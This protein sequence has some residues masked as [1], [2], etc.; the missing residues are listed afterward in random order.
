MDKLEELAQQ[1][2][3]LY[4]Q[5]IDEAIDVL[6]CM[7]GVTERKDLKKLQIDLANNGYDLVVCNFEKNK[8]KTFVYLTNIKNKFIKG[9]LI[10]FDFEKGKINKE[11]IKSKVK[12]EKIIKEN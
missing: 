7:A 12:F 2:V 4:N 6:L 1:C 3:E 10:E 8:S 5:K 9:Y 11:L